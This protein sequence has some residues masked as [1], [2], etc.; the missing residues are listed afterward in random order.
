MTKE[1]RSKLCSGIRVVSKV[2]SAHGRDAG[3]QDADV[4]LPGRPV[5]IVRARFCSSLAQVPYVME[6]PT[7]AIVLNE[8]CW[9]KCWQWRLHATGC[10][11]APM[12]LV[13][14]C[15]RCGGVELL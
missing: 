10:A 5:A 4:V 11:S 6:S 3:V 1:A 9:R 8:L 12:V 2:V 7:A 14:S 13:V 15:A